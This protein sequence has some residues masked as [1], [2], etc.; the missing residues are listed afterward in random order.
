MLAIKLYNIPEDLLD[1]IS[2]LKILNIDS[3]FLGDEA[4]RSIELHKI[5]L[6][7]KIKRYFVFQTF[8]NPKYLNDHPESYS[9]TSN[10]KQAID[11]WVE[12]VCPTDREYQVELLSRLKSVIDI[13]DP[14]GISLDFIRQ[15]I[16]WEKTYTE[17]DKR[18]LS[19]CNC[20]NCQQDPRNREEVITDVVKALSKRARE[21][22][23]NIIVDLHSVPWKKHEFRDGSISLSGQNLR[24][25]SSFVDFIT[26]MCYSH[27]LKKSN[28]WIHEVVQDHSEQGMLPIIPAIQAKECYLKEYISDDQYREILLSALTPPSAGVIIWSWDSISEGEK[29]NITKE[30]FSQL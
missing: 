11:E 9:I 25:I 5:L 24:E 16:F 13:Y 2:K 30:I 29:F 27:M 14:D 18:V 22:K 21:I 12:F 10:G 6:D 19:S 23:P 7:H 20:I 1:F 26:P 3:V 4:S 8:Y 17:S 15:F 28:N